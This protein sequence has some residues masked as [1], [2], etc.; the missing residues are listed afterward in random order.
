MFVK[1]VYYVHDG[2]KEGVSTDLK[3]NTAYDFDFDDY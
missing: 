1:M 2:V 3:T